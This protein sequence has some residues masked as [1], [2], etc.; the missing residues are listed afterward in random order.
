MGVLDVQY[1]VLGAIGTNVYFLINRETGEGIV[2]D[3]ADDARYIAEQSRLRGYALKAILLTHGHFDHFYAAEELRGLTGAPIYAYQDEAQVLADPFLNRSKVWAQARTLRADHLFRDGEECELAGMSF[4]VLH[5]PGHTAGS[6]CY[7]FESEGVLIAGDT[8][9]YESY[10]RTDLGTG[11]SSAI[12]RSLREVL[13]RLPP[14]TKVYPGH[15]DFTD[16]A[17]ELEYNPAAP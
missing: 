10:G 15:G 2:V 9:F 6:C 11:S 7:Y 1:R 4:R 13:F 17:H 3:P 8:L 16:I 5:T 12:I 14:Q